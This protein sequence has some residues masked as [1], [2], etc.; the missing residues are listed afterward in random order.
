MRKQNGLAG[1][2]VIIAIIVI[3]IFSGLIISLMYNNVIQNVK[4][5]KETLAMIYLTEISENIGIQDYD[6]ENYSLIGTEYTE[7]IEENVFVPKKVIDSYKVEMAVITEFEG[8][9][10]NED[11]LKKV[12][13]KLTYKVG[14]KAY[15]CSMERIKIRE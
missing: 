8:I 10:D 15:I 5:K 13:I 12:Q 2:D 11:I 14:N 9:T 6:H 1:M 7:I 4:L 3:I